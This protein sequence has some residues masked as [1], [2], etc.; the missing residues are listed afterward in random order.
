MA[1]E[2]ARKEPAGVNRVRRELRRAVADRLDPSGMEALIRG[3]D[4]E[5]RELAACLAWVFEEELEAGGELTDI[6]EAAVGAYVECFRTADAMEDLR[7]ALHRIAR[8][9]GLTDDQRLRAALLSGATYAPAKPGPPGPECGDLGQ[10]L[11]RL[12]AISASAPDMAMSETIRWL[13]RRGAP[14]PFPLIEYLAR[15]PGQAPVFALAFLAEHP[16]EEI[17]EEAIKALSHSIRPLARWFLD[18]MASYAWRTLDAAEDALNFMAT[19]FVELPQIPPPDGCE[20][21][22]SHADGR[23]SRSLIA[24][25]PGPS[26]TVSYAMALLNEWVG[27]K[28]SMGKEGM[29]REA[30]DELLREVEAKEMLLRIDRRCAETLIRHA[31]YVARYGEHPLSMD[32]SARRAHFGDMSWWP[33][34]HVPDLSAYDAPPRDGDSCGPVALLDRRPY[35]DWWFESPEAYEFVRKLPEGRWSK[36]GEED[37][38]GFVN[39]LLAPERDVYACRL[40]WTLELSAKFG[41][42][43]EPDDAVK[44]YYALIDDGI[45]PADIPFLRRAAQISIDKIGLNIAHG[46]LKPTDY[47][48]EALL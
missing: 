28:D 17:A 29:P 33:A 5:L 3:L 1:K 42:A 35:S 16:D 38:D 36:P 30:A 47:S 14:V 8:K 6:V 10:A 11:E 25:W 19:C 45:Q 21:F 37:I 40:A 4:G 23:G 24:R 26:G 44:L 20:Y 31:L 39:E 2:P 34:R 41:G 13:L 9:R 48:L 27:V 15:L 18:G 12:A 43:P 22:V 46:Y 32:F 7:D